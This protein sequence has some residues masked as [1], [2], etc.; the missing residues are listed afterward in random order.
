MKLLKFAETR[1][2]L[3]AEAPL[4]AFELFDARPQTRNFSFYFARKLLFELANRCV[5]FLADEQVN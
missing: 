2:V 4:K 3:V 1:L 5:F